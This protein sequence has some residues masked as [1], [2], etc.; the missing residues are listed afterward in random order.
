MGLRQHPGPLAILALALLAILA[1][2]C[3]LPGVPPTSLVGSQDPTA[4]N[5]STDWNL[6]A[7]ESA[8]PAVPASGST[9]VATPDSPP[10]LSP[11]ALAMQRAGSHY[12]R[13]LQAMRS[14]NAD[15]AEWEFDTALETLLDMNL[16][17]QA[18]TSLLGLARLPAF[19]ATPWLASLAGPS[20]DPMKEAPE[21][22]EPDEP[23]LDAPALLGPEDLQ[24]VAEAPP[25]GASPLPEPDAQKH[26]IPVVFNEQVKIFIQ[27]FQNRK[28]GVITRAFERASR[29]LPM[30]RKIFREK[31]LPEDLLN[32]AFIESAVNPRATSRAKAAGIWQFIPSTGRLYGMR[33]SWWMDER[34]DPEKSTRAAAEYLKNLHRMFESWP[35]ALAAYNAGEGKLLSAIQRQ[36]TRDFWSLRLPKETQLFVPAFMAMTI[37]AREPDRYGFTPPPEEPVEADTVL[38]RHPTDLKLIAQAARTTVEEIRDLNPELVR[39]ATPPDVPRYTLRIPAG[40]RDEFLAALDR[41]PPA[42]RITW[43]RHQIRKGETPASIARRHRVDLQAILEM[44]GLRKRQALKPGGTLLIPLARAVAVGRTSPDEPP[45]AAQPYTVKK[46]DTLGKIARA[47]AV[48]PEDLRRWNSLPRHAALRPGRTLK[49]LRPAQAKAKAAPRS[50]TPEHSRVGQGAPAVRRYV[51]KRGDTLWKI[52]RAHAVSPEDLRR[53]NSL[54]RDAALRPGQELQIRARAS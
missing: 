7:Q 33:S 35:L 15:Q 30:M 31:G 26:D 44:N 49:I 24:A 13:G 11:L 20:R 1:A 37:I 14:G 36:R 25:E 19:P 45:A 38:L 29:Y 54:P 41:I 52:A 51:V 12:E 23:T 53:W 9:P 5:L 34:R 47:H 42:E 48:S 2:S 27:Y 43:V 21:L 17:G 39:W 8:S 46:G 28:W 10:A 22:T 6:P 50:R 16:N 3:T 4:L 18:P 32:L 40:R